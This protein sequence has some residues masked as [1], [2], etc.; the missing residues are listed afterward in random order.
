MTRADSKG[1]PFFSILQ[2]EEIL[3]II[4]SFVI[5]STMDEGHAVGEDYGS[6][7][8]KIL[9]TLLCARSVCGK[10]RRAVGSLHP[11]GD[12]LKLIAVGW[13]RPL[14]DNVNCMAILGKLECLCNI[15]PGIKTHFPSLFEYMKCKDWERLLNFIVPTLVKKNDLQEALQFVKRVGLIKPEALQTNVFMTNCLMLKYGHIMIHTLTTFNINL[16]A[17]N[18]LSS[19]TV[20]MEAVRCKS[21]YVIEELVLS[22]FPNE[23][24]YDIDHTVKCDKGHDVFYYLEQVEDENFKRKAGELLNLLLPPNREDREKAQKMAREKFY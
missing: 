23:G 4:M 14:K 2:S 7:A 17:K 24:L 15:M 3:T 20:L 6:T 19:R 18:D 11:G 9:K 12:F 1:K 5:G 22:V 10:F 8:D 16:N 21:L 13:V